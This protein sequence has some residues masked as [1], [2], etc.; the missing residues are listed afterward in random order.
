MAGTSFVTIRRLT[1]AIVVK[2]E[3][4]KVGEF[5]A[6]PVINDVS[7]AAPAAGWRVAID[8]SEVMLLASAGIGAILTIRKQCA[9]AGGKLAL[10][11]L[12]PDLMRML[13]STHLDKLIQIH[14]T[15]EAALRAVA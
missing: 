12:S 9:A 10:F 4:E 6:A 3:R 11:G 2:L 14:P 15:E 8:L 13:K 1:S 5:E 7:A